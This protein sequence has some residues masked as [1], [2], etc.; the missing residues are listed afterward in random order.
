MAL[1]TVI[2]LKDSASAVDAAVA[3]KISE[4]DRYPLEPGKWIVD[5]QHTTARELST[6]LGL[7][8]AHNHL[9]VSML[10]YS[11]R[12]STDLWEWLSA[13]WSKTNG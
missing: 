13:R 2:A 11:G 5:S 7:R 9:V 1:F 10:G 6:E 4:K 3:G 8:E 12:S